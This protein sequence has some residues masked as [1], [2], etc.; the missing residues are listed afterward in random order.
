MH[1]TRL[2]PAAAAAV[3]LTLTATGCKDSTGTTITLTPTEAA[4]LSGEIGQALS[5]GGIA[6]NQISVIEPPMLAFGSS[7]PAGPITVTVNCVGGGTVGVSGS[8]TGT[9]SSATFDVT[10]TFNAC[11]TAHF[12]VGGSLHLTGN[13]SSS[14]STFTFQ[15]TVKGSLSVQHLTDGRSGNCGIDFTVNGSINQ[16]TGAVTVSASGNVC[17]INASTVVTR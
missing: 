14:Q 13:F 7:G 9:S 15:E 17:G 2:F 4:E 5:G 10:E 3:A 11:K 8:T 6:L 16:S 1:L 12:N